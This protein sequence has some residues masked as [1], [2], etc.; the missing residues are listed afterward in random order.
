MSLIYEND[1]CPVCY[2]EYDT[3]NINQ[4]DYNKVHD[5]SRAYIPICGHKLCVKCV[6]QIIYFSNALCPTCRIGMDDWDNNSDDDDDSDDDSDYDDI[7]QM[8]EQDE[9][10][11]INNS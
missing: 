9:E 6:Y 5:K 2:C 4:H 3:S 10:N 1:N 8:L 11:E 7:I